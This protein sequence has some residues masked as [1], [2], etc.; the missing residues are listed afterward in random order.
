MIQQR[1]VL[2]TLAICLLTISVF[3]Q[4]NTNIQSEVKPVEQPNK[5]ANLRQL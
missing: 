4:K 2:L 3:A 1:F 5:F